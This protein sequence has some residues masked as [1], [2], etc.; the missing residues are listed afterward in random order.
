MALADAIVRYS[1]RNQNDNILYE[2]NEL[3]SILRQLKRDVR[4]VSEILID[5]NLGDEA[6]EAKEVEE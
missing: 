2:V 3:K 5:I 4:D 6:P 1:K